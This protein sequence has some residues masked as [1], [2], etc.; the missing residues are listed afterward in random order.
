VND[1]FEQVNKFNNRDDIKIFLSTLRTG[2]S[3]INLT[4]ADTV[5]HYDLW[6]NPAV[7]NQATDRVH[8][9]G[10]N[11]QVYVYKFVTK[12]TIEEKIMN[13]QLEKQKQLQ[14]LIYNYDET[15]IN[16]L[17]MQDFKNIFNI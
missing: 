8:R 12:G 14:N 15:K 13:L 10:Q 1:R 11:K 4:S 17:N 5:I 9:I 2:G 7:Q 6:W 16:K 3:G